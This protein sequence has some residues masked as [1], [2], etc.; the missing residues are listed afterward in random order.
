[1]TLGND[2]G[3]CRVDVCVGR[4]GAGGV[5]GQRAAAVTFKNIVLTNSAVIFNVVLFSI[6]CFD[7]TWTIS[8]ASIRLWIKRLYVRPYLNS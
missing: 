8:Y 2:A 1:M 4:G 3:W 6:N 5:G 7:V